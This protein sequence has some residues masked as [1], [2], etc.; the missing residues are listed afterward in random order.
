[1][2][3]SGV[4][5]LPLAVSDKL[6][7]WYYLEIILNHRVQLDA[8]GDVSVTMIRRKVANPTS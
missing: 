4:T 8:D 3:T 6:L 1:M 5:F 2:L 7:K